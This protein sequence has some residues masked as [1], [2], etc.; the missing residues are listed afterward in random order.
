MWVPTSHQ[1]DWSDNAQLC[2]SQTKW[3]QSADALRPSAK[4]QVSWN[5]W[6]WCWCV[7]QIFYTLP[8]PVHP[9]LPENPYFP[10]V[11]VVIPRCCLHRKRKQRN[12]S[13]RRSPS[14]DSWGDSRGG[15]D[16]RTLLFFHIQSR[17]ILEKNTSIFKILV[18]SGDSGVR[19]SSQGLPTTLSRWTSWSGFTGDTNPTEPSSQNTLL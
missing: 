9:P 18:T 19:N 11:M 3:R 8:R 17:C 16:G 13:N 14:D 5:F 12:V 4:A 15:D 6:V 1:T 10:E 7:Q 2:H